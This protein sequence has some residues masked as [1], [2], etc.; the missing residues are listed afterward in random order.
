MTLR[1]TEKYGTISTDTMHGSAGGVF[2]GLQG[3]DDFYN[4]YNAGG[5]VY[6]GGSGS[7]EYWMVY[8]PGFMTIGETSGSADRI[9][10]TGL[11]ANRSTTYFAT[12]DSRHL[13]VFDTAS[14]QGVL[15]LDWT[16]P[17]H[18]I[19]SFTLADGIFNYNQIISFMNISPNNLGDYTWANA[20]AL[21]PNLLPAGTNPTQ[22]SEAIA[23][24][25]NL[26]ISLESPNFSLIN[27]QSGQASSQD[28]A[29]YSGPTNY[30][31]LQFFGTSGGEA[32]TGTA[33]SDFING[34]GGDDAISSGLG[35]DVLDGGT[36]SNFLTGGADRDIFFLD[37]RGGTTTWATITDWQAGEELSVWGWKP[38]VSKSTWVSS[39]GAPGW[40]G[41]TMHGDLDGNGV[42]D[43]SVTWTGKARSSLPTPLEYDGLL[44]FT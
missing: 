35:D 19:E 8:G 28:A 27:T 42:I 41:V 40:T 36:G 26:G 30:L 25:K 11:G 16:I 44:W 29:V 2:F 4:N 5:F 9:T 38:G 6:V 39:A 23:Y 21:N 15:L 24:Y 34:F 12:I 10:A 1:F 33:F 7:D 17:A 43:T 18:R 31:N 32:V 37:G 20:I 3:N 13:Y 14:N 22:L